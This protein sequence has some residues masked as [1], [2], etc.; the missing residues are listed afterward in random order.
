MTE[1]KDELSMPHFE[2]RLWGELEALHRQR[3]RAAPDRHVR[4]R[5]L[6]AGAV[7]AAAAVVVVVVSLWTP[8]TSPGPDRRSPSSEAAAPLD[9]DVDVVQRV[10]SATAVPGESIVHTTVTSGGDLDNREAWY[11][12]VTAA[13][14]H[15]TTTVDGAPLT[16]AGWPEPPAVDAEPAPGAPAPDPQI[17]HCDPATKLAVDAQGR[18]SPCETDEAPPPQPDHAFRYV[19]HCDRTWVDGT[20]AV[21]VEPGWG[22]LTLYLGTGHIV[23]D[24]TEVVDG[25][26]LY[27]LRNR[28]GTYVFLVDPETYLPVRMTVTADPSATYYDMNG[29]PTD[30]PP[31][32]VTSFEYLPRTEEQLALL[33]PPV[34][35]GYEERDEAAAEKCVGN[36]PYGPGF[37]MTSTP[38]GGD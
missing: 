13:A 4:R 33:T 19:D 32:K 7:A 38:D 2:D 36:D 14:R 20:A 21:V 10:R 22:I 16:D 27:R 23:Q 24:G 12:Q 31:T 15:R 28:T 11:D 5:V 35:D 30:P 9:P 26:A 25:R 17:D 6:F 3:N 29:E 34:P 37:V 8:S 1:I 18:I